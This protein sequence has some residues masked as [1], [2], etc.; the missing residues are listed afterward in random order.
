MRQQIRFFSLLAICLISFPLNALACPAIDNII[1]TN[2]DGQLRISF[3]G[4]SIAAGVGGTGNGYQDIVGRRFSSAR[5]HDYAT[6]GIRSQALFARIR[7]TINS[8]KPARQSNSLLSADYIFVDVGRNDFWD[9]RP[10]TFTVRNIMRIKRFLEKQGERKGL[11]SPEVIVATMVPNN[12]SNQRPFVDEI[13]RR[14]SN[15]NIPVIRFDRMPRPFISGDGL[16]PNQQGYVRLGRMVNR[17]LNR[18]FRAEAGE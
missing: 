16:H 17:Y 5:V 10:T 9:D 13:S 6:P 2:C 14:L 11:G 18:N 12:R 3:V 1:D 4:D 15:R 8:G 7:R